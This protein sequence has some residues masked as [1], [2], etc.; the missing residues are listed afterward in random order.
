[1]MQIC[2]SKGKFAFQNTNGLYVICVS[3]RKSLFQNTNL[4]F[5]KTKTNTHAPILG[6][7]VSADATWTCR[8]SVEEEAILL[9][10]RYD[11][12]RH[13]WAPKEMALLGQE[14]RRS[15]ED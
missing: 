10:Q 1:M 13:M 6:V 15:G 2:V 11:I 12:S 8:Q 14:P 3:K 4:C 9:R 5:K 7:I